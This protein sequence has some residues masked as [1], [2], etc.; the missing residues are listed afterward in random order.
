MGLAA[1]R[2]VGAILE[3]RASHLLDD[4]Q[5]LRLELPCGDLLGHL[6]L[7]LESIPRPRRRARVRARCRTDRRAAKARSRRRPA[8]SAGDRISDR[9]VEQ[10]ARGRSRVVEYASQSARGLPEE[11]ADDRVVADDEERDRK[12]F[13]DGFGHGG[14]SIAGRTDQQY[15]MPRLQALRA[16]QVCP[17][18]LLHELPAGPFADIRQNE[19]PETLAGRGLH[20]VIPNPCGRLRGRGVGHPASAA[21]ASQRARQPVCEDIVL[22]DTLLGDDR[23][24]RRGHLLAVSRRAGPDQR[25]E[26]V[27]TRHGVLSGARMRRA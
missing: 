15:P 22:L 26:K 7:R 20:H 6:A 23:L 2:A 8:L 10:H 9:G 16:Q 17:M 3:Y 13:G 18:L 5:T 27:A 21:A 1:A 11:A 19:V 24:Y 14:L 4:A 25:D 12:R